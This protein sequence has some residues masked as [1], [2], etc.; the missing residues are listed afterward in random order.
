MDKNI[1]SNSIKDSF[2]LIIN[3]MVDEKNKKIDKKHYADGF[4]LLG[5]EIFP[6]NK[7]PFSENEIKK[8]GSDFI[9]EWIVENWSSLKEEGRILF[10]GKLIEQLHGNPKLS[11]RFNVLLCSKLVSH[12]AESAIRFLGKICQQTKI[13]K[14]FPLNKDL[15]LQIRSF[16]LKP[17]QNLIK[18]LPLNYSIPG[19]KD[20]AKYVVGAAFL[21]NKK[22]KTAGEIAQLQVLKW[23][24]ESGIG[25]V[26]PGE[27]AELIRKSEAAAK[28][29]SKIQEFLPS[30]PDEIKWEEA[31]ITEQSE[32][33]IAIEGISTIRQPVQVLPSHLVKQGDQD[34]QTT[35]SDEKKKITTISPKDEDIDQ[36]DPIS[37]LKQLQKYIQEMQTAEKKSHEKITRLEKDN[38]NFLNEISELG[39]KQEDLKDKL[40]V[41]QR[42]LVKKNADLTELKTN[43]TTSQQDLSSLRQEKDKLLSQLEEGKAHY[44][45]KLNKFSRTIE[46]KSNHKQEVIINRIR[47]SLRPEYRNLVKIENID[48]T[49]KTAI[50]VRSLLKRIFSKLNTE[51]IDFA[52]DN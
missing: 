14:T 39:K 38:N 12:F 27:I 49:V 24:K 3:S 25:L 11:R 31:V 46:A 45:D 16:F 1:S 19:T 9:A 42:E 34:G 26:V 18:Q 22:G 6:Q 17:K 4:D 2:S 33:H 7:I 29:I 30:F 36:F 47:E 28:N 51:G 37:S 32:K 5:A 15:C 21:G 8:V 52:G 43:L 20:V 48:M 13:S 44:N 50:V 40:N 35:P 10:F 23:I 41:S